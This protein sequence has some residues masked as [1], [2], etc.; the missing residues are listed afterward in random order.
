[1]G[2]T[3]PHIASVP[4]RVRGQEMIDP[5]TYKGK[6]RQVHSHIVSFYFEK[7]YGIGFEDINRR[8]R[9]TDMSRY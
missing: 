7:S 1:M 3:T 4:R 9:L 5:T 6:R 8:P 2:E